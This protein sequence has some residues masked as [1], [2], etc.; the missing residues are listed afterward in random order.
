MLNSDVEGSAG[1]VQDLSG[2]LS[3]L[4]R[5]DIESSGIDSDPVEPL[6]EAIGSCR[7][8]EFPLT[9]AWILVAASSSMSAMLLCGEKERSK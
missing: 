9:F 2:A 6:L 3:K 7:R 5:T 1:K 8:T 4:E